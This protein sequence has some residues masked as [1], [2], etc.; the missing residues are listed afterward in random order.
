MMSKPH[1]SMQNHTPEPSRWKILTVLLVPLFM[2]LISVSIVNVALPSI[3]VGLGAGQSELQWVLSGYALTFG[4][5][6]VA[7]GRAG[8]VFGRVPIFIS[9]ISLFTVASVA[10]GLA[11][12]PLTLNIA[13]AA[14]GLGSGLLSPQAVGMIQQYFQG[15]E[16]A[17]AFGLFGSVVGVSFAIGPLLGG[18]LIAGAG[19][20]E[21]WRWTFFINVPIG[22]F[23]IMLAR[24]W[25]PGQRPRN[26]VTTTR[27]ATAA[28]GRFRDLDPVGALLLGLAVLA[29]LAPFVESHVSGWVWLALPFGLLLAAAWVGW[30]HRYKAL[31]R[32]P[33]V[34][35]AIFRITSFTNGTL[36]VTLYFMGIT[37]VWVLIALYMQDGLG[38]TALQ[39]GV[40]G[41]PAATFA[42][43]AANWAGRSVMRYGRKVVIG[44]IISALFG[45]AASVV[46]IQLQVAGLV[47]EWWLLLTLSF[48]GIGQGLV[49][50]PNQTL[51]LAEVPLQYAGSSGGILQTGQRIGTSLGIAGVTSISFIVLAHADWPMAISA[52][53]L[54]IAAIVGTTL[55]V[56]VKDLRD[57]TGEAA[58]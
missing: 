22:I 40:L 58:L 19:A 28:A 53:F 3:Q 17:R 38:N 42:A 25:L 12:D 35:L 50:S 56:A 52:G 39:A 41:L 46:I 57:R 48:I 55:A 26:Q 16:R 18:V 36:L 24:L 8:D 54:V 7:A 49:I 33:M 37:S 34:D 23:A 2:S 30:E 29:I 10:A 31:G 14:Q 47:S 51:T 21:G 6:L 9:G 1:H 5:I 11:S 27:A 32:S 20:E 45:L 15:A 43:F 13:R 4:F 44:G